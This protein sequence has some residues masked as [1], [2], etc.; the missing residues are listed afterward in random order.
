[1]F[2]SEPG[3]SGENLVEITLIRRKWRIISVNNK[4]GQLSIVVDYKQENLWDEFY[5]DN[6]SG[7]NARKAS[8]SFLVLIEGKQLYGNVEL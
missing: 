7:A 6:N 2:T 3:Q 8:D 4:E 1:M 5:K